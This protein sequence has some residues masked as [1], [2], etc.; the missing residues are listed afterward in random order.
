MYAYY[1]RNEYPTVRKLLIT[2]REAGLYSGSA[3]SLITIMKQIGFKYLKKNEKKKAPSI[4]Y[5]GDKQSNK[6]Q[7]I[8]YLSMRLG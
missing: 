7:P 1:T 5:E 6:L 2:L 8:S 4:V 3:T